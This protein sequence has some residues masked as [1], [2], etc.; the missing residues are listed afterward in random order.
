MVV[1]GDTYGLF[2]I[3]GQLIVPEKKKK[4]KR[5]SRRS[6]RRVR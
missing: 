4:K 6:R 3:E 2:D 1:R 5:Q